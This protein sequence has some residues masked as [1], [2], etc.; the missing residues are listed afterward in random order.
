MVQFHLLRNLNLL[1]K[2]AFWRRFQVLSNCGPN[3]FFLSS[4][5]RASVEQFSDFAWV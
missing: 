5:E 4:R 2:N 3:T 1:K